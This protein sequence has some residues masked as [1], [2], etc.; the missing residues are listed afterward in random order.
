MP[1]GGVNIN[2]MP[3]YHVG[4]GAVTSFGTL[5]YRGTFVILPGFDPALMLEAF[6][7]Y[8]GT[9]TLVVP[10]MLIAL[11]EHPD[12]EKRDLSSVQRSD[13]GEHRAGHADPPHRQDPR[14]WHHHLV[15]AD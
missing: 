14:L 2:A 7:T 8:R 3:M 12:R 10:T 11:L 1:D 15:R 5:A 4:G 6:E 9:H 13:G